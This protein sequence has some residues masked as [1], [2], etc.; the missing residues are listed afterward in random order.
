MR[1]L[2]NKNEKLFENL[3]E[4]MNHFSHTYELEHINSENS[5][6]NIAYNSL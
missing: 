5:S 3:D 2:M 6:Y 4:K 1:T